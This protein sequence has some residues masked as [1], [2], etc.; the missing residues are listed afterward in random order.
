MIGKYYHIK[1]IPENIDAEVNKRS[2]RYDG[3]RITASENLKYAEHQKLEKQ[4]IDVFTVKPVLTIVLKKMNIGF[5]P[6]NLFDLGTYGTVYPTMTITDTWG[7]LNV[8]SGEG[9]LMKDWQVVY[10]PLKK[11]MTLTNGKTV[12]GDGWKLN[13]VP[14][15]KIIPDGLNYKLI[16]E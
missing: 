14:G 11:D 5:N 8:T 16:K 3:A 2:G 4:Y 10:L 12:E 15:W 7:E 13:L 6:N 1:A 9:A